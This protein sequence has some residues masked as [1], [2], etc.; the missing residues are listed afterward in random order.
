[1]AA[2]KATRKKAKKKAA[3]RKSARKKAGAKK[4]A[5]KAK[6]DLVG[7][8]LPRSL[9]AFGKQLRRDLT[10]VEKQIEVAGKDTRRSLARIVRDASHQL[11][12][13]E[14]RGEREWRKLSRN[15]KK[16]VERVVKRVQKVTGG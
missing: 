16:D 5:R 1:M 2:R 4:R 14:A 13:L 3:K 11:G 10:A 15:A 7:K 12:T 6:V 8:E 9:K